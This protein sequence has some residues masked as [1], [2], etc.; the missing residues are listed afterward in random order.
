MGVEKAK[1]AAKASRYGSGH[2]GGRGRPED[3]D[4]DCALLCRAVRAVLVNGDAVL[5]GLTS[6]GGAVRVQTF[7]GSAKHSRYAT[8]VDELNTILDSLRESPDM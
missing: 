6:D 5:F 3:W 7:E 2:A 1:A 4:W 8:N